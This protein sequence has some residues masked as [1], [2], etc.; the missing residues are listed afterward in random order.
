M[1]IPSYTALVLT[2]ENVNTSI[3]SFSNLMRGFLLVYIN[4]FDSSSAELMELG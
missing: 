2:G 3:L 1:G 4:Q